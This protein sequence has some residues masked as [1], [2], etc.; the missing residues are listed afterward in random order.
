[1]NFNFPLKI[2]LSGKLCSDIIFNEK[3]IEVKC[4]NEIHLMEE[5]IT[6]LR[7][8]DNKSTSVYG[9]HTRSG[10]RNALLEKYFDSGVIRPKSEIRQQLFPPKEKYFLRKILPNLN[11]NWQECHEKHHGLDSFYFESQMFT[12]WSQQIASLFQTQHNQ[13]FERISHVHKNSNNFNLTKFC[14]CNV[15]FFML[16]TFRQMAWQDLGYCARNNP[17]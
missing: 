12:K 14:S 10:E 3:E 11:Q 15:L 16:H 1:M 6:R 5:R 8:C 4:W 13:Y 7:F 17:L 9:R 2:D